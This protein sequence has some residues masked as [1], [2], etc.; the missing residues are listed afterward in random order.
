MKHQEDS[1]ALLSCFL[2]PLQNATGHA[3]AVL[4]MVID[5]ASM[6]EVRK[7]LR[8]A[9]AVTFAENS[10]ATEPLEHN[11]AWETMVQ[12]CTR[13]LPNLPN[14]PTCG[15]DGT[16]TQGKHKSN[17]VDFPEDRHTPSYAKPAYRVRFLPLPV[18]PTW[19]PLKAN[20]PFNPQE[21]IAQSL[22]KAML[23][24]FNAQ[25]PTSQSLDFE[26]SSQ[27]TASAEKARNT[28]HVN[29]AMTSNQPMGMSEHERLREAL[30]DIL[31]QEAR[32]HGLEV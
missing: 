4:G 8:L 9:Q 22:G 30:A 19:P 12:W 29:V 24:A 5:S 25:N 14:A 6:E 10:A 1:M 17:G 21:K 13:P 27:T 28:F 23:P 15:E 20:G 32:R 3:A 31:A 2:H 26:S 18:Q 11:Q 7:P 16:H